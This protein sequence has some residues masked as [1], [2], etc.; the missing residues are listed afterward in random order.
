[1]EAFL[2]EIAPLGAKMGCL[3]VQLPPS[4]EMH[5]RTARSFFS[6]LRG[7]YEGPLAFE[8]RH[9]SWFGRDVDRMLED[10]H[11][12][13]VAA[14]PPRAAGAVEPAGW[15]GI[16][17]YRL[18]GSPRMYFSPYEGSFLD[19]IAKDI[20]GLS[21][22]RV[23]CWCIFDNTGSGAAAGDALELARRLTR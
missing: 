5:A 16:A 14:D 8:P 21:R 1:V 13:R 10:L 6:M 9:G 3:L 12:A 11:V 2:E 17:Y 4:L 23:P 22:S 15:R 7:R 20:R 19:R 18:H